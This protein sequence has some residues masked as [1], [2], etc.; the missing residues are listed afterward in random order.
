MEKASVSVLPQNKIY[1][2]DFKNH[3]CGKKMLKKAQGQFNCS[4]NNEQLTLPIKVCECCR[5]VIISGKTYI[6][7][8]DSLNG[9]VFRNGRTGQPILNISRS[10]NY[11]PNHNNNDK[12]LKASS[13][14]IWALKH[15]F[16]GGGCSGK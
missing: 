10:D 11:C 1:V 8:R 4:A 14:V 16:Q 2:N 7:N 5:A 13:T 9:Y 12:K 3:Q 6:S 15:P